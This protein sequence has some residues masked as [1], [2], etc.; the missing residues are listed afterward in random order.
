MTTQEFQTW[1]RE[2]NPRP[3]VM[4]IVNVTPDSFSDGGRFQD[5]AAALAHAR[6]LVAEGADLLDIGG[7]STRPGAG[8]VSTAEQ[9]ARVTP[10]IEAMQRELGV[11]MSVDT[12]LAA[13][14]AAAVE[15]GASI[16]NDVSGG[17]ED[18]GMLALAGRR[19]LPI[20][21][22]H[23]KGEPGTMQQ[24]PVYVDVVAEVCAYLKQ[25]AAKAEAAG[26]P[27]ERI[28]LD[29]G[30]GFGKTVDHN[31][32]L[33]RE[34]RELSGLGYRLLL[35]TSRKRFIGAIT[36]VNRPEE[37]VF[38]STATVAWGVSHGAAIVRVHDVAATVQT[39][40]M[41]SAIEKSRP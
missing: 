28:L 21:L 19:Q 32:R 25:Q 13:V 38:G 14:A 26:V 4:G 16:V 23:M 29:P 8:R 6:K 2:P 9:I 24:N 1:L 27:R 12:T 18:A 22:M 15:A 3:L 36:G 37:R 7:E 17:G 33:L 35:G 34:L 30:I 41:I 39:I 40:R 31:L 11:A 5:P 20:V 10:V